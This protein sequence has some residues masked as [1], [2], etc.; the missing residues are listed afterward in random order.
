MQ[1]ESNEVDYSHLN[2]YLLSIV[3][4]FDCEHIIPDYV[5]P[6]GVVVREVVFF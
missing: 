5:I 6:L 1:Y 3:V 4:K 2:A